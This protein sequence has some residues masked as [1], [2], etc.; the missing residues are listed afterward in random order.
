MFRK[1][2]REESGYTLVEVMVSIIILAIAIIPMAG[3]FDMGLNSVTTSCKYDKGR[4]LANLKLEQAKNLPYEA[5]RT[6]FPSQATSN[7]GAPGAS[8]TITSSSVTRAQD[9][10]VPQGFSYTVTK[11]YVQQLP[12][13]PGS[14]SMPFQVSPSDTDTHLL[15]ITVTVSWAGNEYKT[16]G[17][18][19]G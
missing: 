8:G 12:L 1:R 2:V 15:R 13:K 19:A 17:A 6:N 4:A 5:V 7:K 18:V 3:M 16:T 10:Q 11:Q 14:A 9:A